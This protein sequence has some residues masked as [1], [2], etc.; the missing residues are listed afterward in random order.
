MPDP[1]ILR[2]IHQLRGSGF[3]FV[4]DSIYDL[5]GE[6]HGKT[7]QVKLQV[8]GTKSASISGGGV[9]RNVPIPDG[10]PLAQFLDGEIKKTLEVSFLHEEG[11]SHKEDASGVTLT[12]KHK[13]KR[14]EVLLPPG[15]PR[16]PARFTLDSYSFEEQI[17]P[18]EFIYTRLDDIG[19]RV[20]AGKDRRLLLK[21]GFQESGKATFTGRLESEKVVV[22]LPQGYPKSPPSVRVG[23][24]HPRLTDE[25]GYAKLENLATYQWSKDPDLSGVLDALRRRIERVH[26]EV[27]RL[28]LETYQLLR[29]SQLR[30]VK[31]NV[32]RWE[33]PVTTHQGITLDLAVDVPKEFPRVPP[34]VSLRNVFPNDHIDVGGS[35][36]IPR[37]TS[38]WTEETHIVEVLEDIRAL[39][40]TD[41][42]SMDPTTRLS[43]E[44]GYLEKYEPSIT[45]IPDNE[46][47]QYAQDLNREVL[48]GWTVTIKGE[49]VLTS[50]TYEAVVLV[51]PYFPQT[52]PMIK[53]DSR[54]DVT[55]RILLFG[56]IH[57]PTG[58]V[59][60]G[61]PGSGLEW[62]G[63]MSLCEAL[64]L[65]KERLRVRKFE[66][67]SSEEFF[68]EIGNILVSD[69][70]TT[71]KPLANNIYLWSGEYKALYGAQLKKVHY[72]VRLSQN[73][74]LSP[75]R[76]SVVDPKPFI[77]DNVET[78]GRVK[79]EF[80]TQKHFRR[81][82]LKTVAKLV[83]TLRPEAKKGLLDKVMGVFR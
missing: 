42:V 34:R 63:D 1:R 81:T 41:L 25:E 3:S 76:V 14:M 73:Y 75:P 49:G 53:F 36:V 24:V 54:L 72:E 20:E 52:P 69:M 44:A 51:D 29:Q 58:L 39:K 19:E 15:Y 47:G 26:R 27:P 21:Q 43:Y 57:S 38:T 40:R 10:L 31:G 45:Q 12:G 71:F 6:F 33:G 9:N 74:P 8:E 59:L 65:V 79:E 82:D 55:E 60:F 68:E 37:L 48:G 70:V 23:I 17:P 77:N 4:G 7:V 61:H 32:E 22:K 2:E 11:F 16:S 35:V 30:P 80:I 46:V 83:K 78:D 13:G 67:T 62:E 18:G 64:E 56:A 66:I 50:R 28:Y 5:R